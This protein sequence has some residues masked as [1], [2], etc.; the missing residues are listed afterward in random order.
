[1]QLNVAR[2]SYTFK[3][4]ES[5]ERRLWARAANAQ[6]ENLAIERDRQQE[7]KFASEYTEKLAD[8]RAEKLAIE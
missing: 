4:V 8:E 6:Q 2:F 5:Y 3:L 7:K 1:M